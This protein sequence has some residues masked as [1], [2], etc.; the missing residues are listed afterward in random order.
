[1]KIGVKSG[2]VAQTFCMTDYGQNYV[3]SFESSASAI[4][5]LK[6][7]EIDAFVIDQDYAQTFAAAGSGLRILDS[8]IYSE[9]YVIAVNKENPDLYEAVE[10]ALMELVSDGTVQRIKDKYLN[11]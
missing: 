8:R 11:D 3:I 5:F 7:G 4:E 9:S 6:L 10:K 2:T 1:M